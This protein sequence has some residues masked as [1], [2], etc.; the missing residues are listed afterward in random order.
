MTPRA[1]AALA[2]LLTAACVVSACGVQQ[3]STPELEPRA[4]VPY[5]LLDTPAPGPTTASDAAVPDGQPRVYFT[6][7]RQLEPVAAPPRTG[8]GLDQLSQLLTALAAGPSAG[9][10]QRGIGTALPPG[11][12]LRLLGVSNAVAR[13]ELAGVTASSDVDQAPYAVAQI[14]LTST[15]L[16]GVEAVEL[17]RQGEQ[18]AAPLPDGT[19]TDRAL[20]AQDYGALSR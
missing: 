5:G 20:R 10:R 12:T 2:A 11:L 6:R 8:N 4:A 15:S 16:R 7:Q 14:V 17:S 9:E 1:G 3:R 18:L 13:V 19:L